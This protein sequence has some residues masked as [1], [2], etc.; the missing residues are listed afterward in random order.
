VSLTADGAFGPRDRARISYCRFQV[1]RL[2]RRLRDPESWRLPIGGTALA[3]APIGARGPE[4]L[5]AGSG[6]LSPEFRAAHREELRPLGSADPH[7]SFLKFATMP[8]KVPSP[9]LMALAGCEWRDPMR[10]RRLV[11]ALITYPFAVFRAGG[12][13]RGLARAVARGRLPDI[14]R[15]R[16]RRG[17]QAPDAAAWFEAHEPRY[18]AAFAIVRASPIANEILDIARVGQVLDSLCAGDRSQDCYSLHR[19]LDAGL[20]ASAFEAGQW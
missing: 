5:R 12:R 7:A 14:V 6:L 11:E 19:A 8:D 2:G 10:D 15:L 9:D 13:T 18:R 20:F 3:D 4:G 16:T 17:A 1:N